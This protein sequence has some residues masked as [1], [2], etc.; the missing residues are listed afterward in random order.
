[1]PGVRATAVLFGA[2]LAA[3]RGAIFSADERADPALCANGADKMKT[4]FPLIL[5]IAVVLGCSR[6]QEDGGEATRRSEPPR[7]GDA[8]STDLKPPKQPAAPIS[9]LSWAEFDEVFNPKKQS[10]PQ[11]K[12]AAWKNFVNKY[13]DWEGTIS[14]FRKDKLNNYSIAVEMDADVDPHTAD[15]NLI[16]QKEEEENKFLS[17]NKGQKIRFTGRLAAYDGDRARLMI[18]VGALK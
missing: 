11:Q 9:D 15:I 14:E 1:L 7:A 13:V 6:R 2:A 17:L 12:E 10:S 8:N 5:I 16:L 18:D 4:I 3:E